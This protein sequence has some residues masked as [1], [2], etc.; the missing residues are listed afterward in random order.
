MG[1]KRISKEEFQQVEDLVEE[2]L[3][4]R[5]IAEKLGRSEG[6]IR[7]LRYRKR[8]VNK[9]EDESK[10]LFQQRDELKRSVCILQGHKRALTNEVAGLKKEKE[11][12]EASINTNKNEL[13]GVLAQALMNLKQQRPDLFIL[14]GQ[15]QMVSLA[16]LFLGLI[17]K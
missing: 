7:N 2:R 16:R 1:G 10:V 8:L 5:E 6:G 11:K 4:N 13:Y 12:L 15:D 14:T 3:T 17:T 9:A